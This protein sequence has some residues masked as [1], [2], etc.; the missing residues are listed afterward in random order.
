MHSIEW[1]QQEIHQAIKG[2]KDTSNW[3]IHEGIELDK[4]N[5]ATLKTTGDKDA[6]N[7]QI[8]KLT[9]K[10]LKKS[11]KQSARH[12]ENIR[13][14]IDQLPELASFH[15][16]IQVAQRK[17]LQALALYS[18]SFK[19]DLQTLIASKNERKLNSARIAIRK[20]SEILRTWYKEVEAQ[21]IHLQSEFSLIEARWQVTHRGYHLEVLPISKI[22]MD[23]GWFD[24]GGT[25]EV[26][27]P[28]MGNPLLGYEPPRIKKH[29]DGFYTVVDGRR[30]IFESFKRGFESDF[31]FQRAFWIH[32]FTLTCLVA[33]EISPAP[34]NG[35][36]VWQIAPDKYRQITTP[37]RKIFTRWLTGKSRFHAYGT[38][39]L[40]PNL[41]RKLSINSQRLLSKTEDGLGTLYS[42]GAQRIYDL[43]VLAKIE[44]FSTNPKK[45]AISQVKR[46]HKYQDAMKQLVA[47]NESTSE[48]E[49][50]LLQK[51][52]AS[53]DKD[54]TRWRL[55]KKM[56]VQ[57]AKLK[58]VIDQLH[59]LLKEEFYLITSVNPLQQRSSI[60]GLIKK[61]MQLKDYFQSWTNEEHGY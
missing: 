35:K 38:K 40:P 18:T 13:K 7:I 6:K 42:D 61:E 20:H 44:E 50:N 59:S 47:Q 21:L 3:I 25:G 57:L 32:K 22:L 46:L 30:R 27:K 15:S 45:L 39:L 28:H 5:L 24:S 53:L 9:L 54:I 1:R 41:R 33:D 19:E 31:H 16:Q 34:A 8:A 37:K 10:H 56:R 23:A 26:P 12:L 36:F 2:L 51:L 52:S 29:Q 58:K 48:V 17:L 55:K 49:D 60:E 43:Q 14:A 11:G 4:L